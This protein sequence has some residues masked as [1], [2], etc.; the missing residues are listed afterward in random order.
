MCVS[1]HVHPCMC[2]SACTRACVCK[3]A[4]S[5]VMYI[6]V[7]NCILGLLLSMH[8][9]LLMPTHMSLQSYRYICGCVCGSVHV[10]VCVLG[11]VHM[12]LALCPYVCLCVWTCA[13]VHVPACEL[14]CTYLWLCQCDAHP[15]TWI[16]GN[17]PVP[18][19]SRVGAQ[20]LCTGMSPRGVHNWRGAG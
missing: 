10:C 7:H 17:D 5:W 1:V 3:S 2:T 13:W 11:C 18:A 15:C 6:N 4:R 14:V 19:V 9:C 12:C 20:P 8:A 16:P